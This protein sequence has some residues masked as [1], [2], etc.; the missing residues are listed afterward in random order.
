M[1][2]SSLSIFAK[3]GLSRFIPAHSA[4]RCSLFRGSRLGVSLLMLIVDQSSF[5]LGGGFLA[6]PLDVLID[7]YKALFVDK[8]VSCISIAGDVV[9]KF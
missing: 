6:K 5:C 1:F 4:C 9:C 2:L 3:A 7:E 8:D